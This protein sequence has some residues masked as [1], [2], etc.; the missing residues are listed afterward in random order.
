MWRARPSVRQ[1]WKRAPIISSPFIDWK[2]ESNSKIETSL[3]KPYEWTWYSLRAFSRLTRTR[4]R[5][6]LSAYSKKFFFSVCI[7]KSVW[8][9]FSDHRHQEHISYFWSSKDMNMPRQGRACRGGY[10]THF[11]CDALLRPCLLTKT[12]E[13]RWLCILCF[14]CHQWWHVFCSISWPF[15]CEAGVVAPRKNCTTVRAHQVPFFQLRGLIC[16]I[17]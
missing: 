4:A 1:F 5:A 14:C 8:E 9:R 2:W 6:K 15:S 13:R 17:N 12:L 7:N 11:R 3:N 16:D 10:S